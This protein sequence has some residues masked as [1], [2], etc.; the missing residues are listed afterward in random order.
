MGTTRRTTK[1]DDVEECSA[2]RQLIDEMLLPT[3]EEDERRHGVDARTSVLDE[4]LQVVRGFEKSFKTF[5]VV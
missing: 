2:I 5:S 4:L 1:L 3:D